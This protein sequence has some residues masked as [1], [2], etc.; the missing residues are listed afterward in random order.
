MTRIMGSGEQFGKVS[1][2]ERGDGWRVDVRPFGYVYSVSGE[3]FTKR[4]D[5]EAVLSIIRMDLRAGKAHADA[6]GRFLGPK[7]KPNLLVPRYQE[8]LKVKQSEVAAG[9]LSPRTLKEY[10]RYARAGGELVYF[11]GRSIHEVTA[12]LLKDWGT[13][14]TARGL[15]AKSRRNVMGALRVFFSWL[16]EHEVVANVPVFKLPRDPKHH[17]QVLSAADQQRVLDAIPE[18][19]RGIHLAMGTM[20]LRPGEARALEVRHVDLERGEL[21]VEQAMKGNGPESPIGPTKTNTKRDVPLSNAL[22]TWLGQHLAEDAEPDA[23]LFTNP[24]TSNRW[25][26]WAVRDAWLSAC[27]A[28]GVRR[29]K[30]YEGTKHSMATAAKSRGAD[31]RAIAAVLGHSDLR[32]T[33]RYAQLAGKHLRNVVNGR[34]GGPARNRPRRRRSAYSAGFPAQ[35][36]QTET[37]ASSRK[38]S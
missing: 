11:E 3:A 10:D 36:K 23:P 30:L 26:H 28:A 27:D 20:G 14:L 9:A 24:N 19:A 5:A 16:R 17:P 31:D 21:L 38:R 34:G 35:S 13:W 1:P 32:S 6:V 8:F 15:S 33:A 29:V 22:R 7:S 37:R 25:S 12:G 2:R 4:G 18:A